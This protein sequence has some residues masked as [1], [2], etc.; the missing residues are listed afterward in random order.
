MYLSLITDAYSKKIVGWCLWPDL[1]SE[2][3]L[4]ALKMAITNEG[5][6]PKLTHHSDRGIQYCCH[7]YVNY[8]KGSKIEISMTENG[9]PYENAVA[10]RVNGI[11]K[12]EYELNETYSDYNVALEATKNAV[13][14]YNYKRPHRS[15]SFMFPIDAHY[16]KGPLKKHWKKRK[17]ASKPE[18]GLLKEPVS[19]NQD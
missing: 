18:T 12:D 16:E 8:L 17:Y 4:N 2:G 5:V 7:D 15:V 3:A 1:T 13:H 10:E 11:L 19:K 14:K 9:D 6:K